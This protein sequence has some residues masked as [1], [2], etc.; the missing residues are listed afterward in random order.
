MAVPFTTHFLNWIRN[1]GIRITRGL[2]LSDEAGAPILPG[3]HYT[4]AIDAAW[5]D[6]RGT[7]LREGQQKAFTGAPPD[8]NPADP[9]TWRVTAPASGTSEPLIVDFPKSMDYALL[10]RMLNIPGVPGQILV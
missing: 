1:S 10:Q 9:G 7:S 8:R 5:H 3:K 2:R 4:L 6:A